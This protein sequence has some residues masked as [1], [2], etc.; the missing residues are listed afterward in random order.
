MDSP[1]PHFD[2]VHHLK[3]PVRDLDVSSEWFQSRL[4]YFLAMEFREDGKLMGCNAGRAGN[5]GTVNPASAGKARDRMGNRKKP[6]ESVNSRGFPL[7]AEG[8]LNPHPLSRTSTS[9]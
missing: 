9:S 5:V 2:G 8:D 4:G 7:C 6:L 3:L 1:I